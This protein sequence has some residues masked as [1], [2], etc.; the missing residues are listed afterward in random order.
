[1]AR[2]R[3]TQR[4]LAAIDAFQ[5]SPEGSK[6]PGLLKASQTLAEGLKRDGHSDGDLS[7]GQK[8]VQAVSNNIPVR[9]DKSGFENDT[10]ELSPGDKAILEVSGSS[11]D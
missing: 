8:A 10:D 6:N 7:A 5:D 2:T 11:L 4:L 1:M 3:E 9:S